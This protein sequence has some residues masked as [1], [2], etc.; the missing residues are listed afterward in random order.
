MDLIKIGPTKQDHYVAEGYNKTDFQELNNNLLFKT[1][2]YIDLD[3]VKSLDLDVYI[4]M[5]FINILDFDDNSNQFLIEP[6]L[7]IGFRNLNSDWLG[8]KGFA[9]NKCKIKKF[10]KTEIELPIAE[11]YETNLLSNQDNYKIN[12]EKINSLIAKNLN[13]KLV[14]EH[15]N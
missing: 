6:F 7:E 13:I 15:I 10:D 1:H 3:F 2:A 4:G 9:I 8:L 11:F 14:I 5:I 12:N